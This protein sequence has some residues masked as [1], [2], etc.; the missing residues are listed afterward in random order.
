MPKVVVLRR[1]RKFFPA[2]IS[3]FSS[4]FPCPK[5]LLE[6]LALFPSYFPPGFVPNLTFKRNGE[7]SI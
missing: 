3:D 4:T 7:E 1:D 5:Q 6:Y 2:T